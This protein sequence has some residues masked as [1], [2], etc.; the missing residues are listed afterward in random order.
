[1][2]IR[3]RQT[4][5]T[6]AR[7]FAAI[8]AVSILFLSGCADE[9][10]AGPP[11]APRNVLIVLLDA[12]SAQHLKDWGYRRDTAPNLSKFADEGV[13][14]LNAH[15]QAANTTPSVWSFFTGK[16]P[17][18][19]GPG[20]TTHHPAE[21]DFTMA[22]AFKAA[23]FRTGAVSESPWV[24]SKYG[25]GKGFDAFK[26]VPALYDQGHE[27]WEREPDGT[28]RVLDHAREWIGEQG[29]ARWFCYVHL[30]RPHDPYDPPEPYASRYGGPHRPYGHPRAEDQIR[31]AAIQNPG[32]I[33]QDDIDY[34]VDLYDANIRYVDKLV[35][36]LMAWLD[37]SGLR[38]DTLVVFMSDH[39]E[40]FMQHGVFGHN[41]TVY[42]EVTRVPLIF[43]APKAAQFKRGERLDLVD[44]V[45]LMPTFNELLGLNAPV[46]Y[47]GESLVS[48]LRDTSPSIRSTS[49]SYTAF[50]HHRVAYR[51]GN[52]KY[53]GKTDAE[54]KAFASHELYDVGK[55]PR[56]KTSLVSDPD[57]LGPLLEAATAHLAAAERRD[58]TGDPALDANTREQ[59]CAMG[60]ITCEE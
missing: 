54:Y 8:S 34:M 59:L 40:A 51:R 43:L 32:S 55:D 4:R 56:E 52:Q 48:T 24:V 37:E 53:I 31:I 50:D 18:I 45:D 16:Y 58:S 20:Y 28:Q 2:P 7:A 33:T 14:F 17:Y 46:E 9:T 3:F 39:G 5:T 27:K 41:T 49:V 36:D 29:D 25:W 1:M 10:P 12:T 15:A 23:G 26:D 57:L 11:Q 30:I 21:T 38:E 47:P 35:G 44:L 42:E 6:I 19:P 22:D 60:Y 13:A